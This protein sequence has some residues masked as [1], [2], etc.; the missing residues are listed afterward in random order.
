LCTPHLS[1]VLECLFCAHSLYPSITTLVPHPTDPLGTWHPVRLLCLSHAIENIGSRLLCCRALC[2][3]L[4]L[5][6][7][8]YCTAHTT[9]LLTHNLLLNTG[10][11]VQHSLPE[12]LESSAHFIAGHGS[13]KLLS[14]VLE[15]R[16]KCLS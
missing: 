13:R 12:L 3:K 8:F 10:Q 9:L 1:H 2:K 6:A 16:G 15:L 5:E 7:G 11:F 4:R 14:D